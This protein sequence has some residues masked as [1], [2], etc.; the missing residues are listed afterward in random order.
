MNLKDKTMQSVRTSRTTLMLMLTSGIVFSSGCT[1]ISD[2]RLTE[3]EQT[4]DQDEDG[5]KNQWL[6]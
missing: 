4:L 5:Y 6:V 2:L 3:K 1:W